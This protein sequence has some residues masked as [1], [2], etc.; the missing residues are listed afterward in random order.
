MLFYNLIGKGGTPRLFLTLAK[1][2][3]HIQDIDVYAYYFD[4][5]KCYPEINRD[6]GII[7]KFKVDRFP[8]ENNMKTRLLYAK[9]YF[10]RM[11]NWSTEINKNIDVINPHE[12]LTYVTSVHIKKKL[13]IP[14]V[15]SCF[16]IPSYVDREQVGT[17]YQQSLTFRIMANVFSHADRSYIKQID[18]VLVANHRIR[19][20][21]ERFYGI[22]AIVAR[23]AGVDIELFKSLPSEEVAIFKKNICNVFGIP[24]GA[25]IILSIG[26]LLGH[27]R[28]E[29]GIKAVHILNDQGYNVHYIIVGS[30]NLQPSYKDILE[31]H[32]ARLGLGSK[33]HIIDSYVSDEQLIMYHNMCDV[34]LFPNIT[35]SWGLAPLESMAVGKPVIVTEGSGVHEVL[36]NN[37]NALIV[38]ER[39]PEDIASKIISILRDDDLRRTLE[40]NASNYVQKEFSFARCA[41]RLSYILKKA[42][43][44]SV[45]ESEVL[46]V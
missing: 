6:I 21:V 31:N 42:S 28:F 8:Q 23:T 43:S 33:V 40:K 20:L 41:E 14:I 5:E 4:K 36:R 29:D 3:Q 15:W 18:Y 2:L 13:E 24:E 35:Q 46:G 37:I 16:D 19:Q 30:S 17:F 32:I 44:R 27:R 26:I 11:P 1:Y 7:T 12:G 22:K 25:K 38:K 45:L 9:D 10:L 34:F 39:S